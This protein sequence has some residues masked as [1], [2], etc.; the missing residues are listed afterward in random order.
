LRV[1]RTGVT[2]PRHLI[3]E[4]DQLA[5]RLG[6]KSRSKLVSE[7]VAYYI[8]KLKWYS[9]DE[10]MHGAITIV[11]DHTRGDLAKRLIEVQHRVGDVVKVAVHL[12]LSEKMCLE[13]I[14]VSGRGADI[15]R[16][17]GEL[18]ELPGVYYVDHSLASSRVTIE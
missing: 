6:V 13:T 18:N 10:T 12:H 3:E 8:S 15:M 5:K 7:A 9:P 4:L 11:Y 17:V 1:T 16:L 14:L 2:I